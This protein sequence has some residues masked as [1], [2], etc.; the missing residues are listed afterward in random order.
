MHDITLTANC[1][2]TFPTAARGKKIRL[3][4]RQDATGSRTVT[5]PVVVKWPGGT[6]PTLTTTASAVDLFEFTCINGTNWL[7]EVVGLDIR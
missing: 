2:L 6:A 4:L 1:A 7:G 3:A 5:W